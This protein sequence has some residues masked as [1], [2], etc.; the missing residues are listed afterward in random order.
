M[1]GASTTGGGSIR[2]RASH[3]FAGPTLVRATCPTNAA[4][5]GSIPK[6][7]ATMSGVRL[8][9][10][11]GPA[12]DILERAELAVDLQQA[13]LQEHRR[14]HPVPQV[15]CLGRQLRPPVHAQRRALPEHVRE[16][17]D[18][19]RAAVEDPVPEGHRLEG[20]IGAAIRAMLAVVE[21]RDRRLGH[22]LG[23]H[24]HVPARGIAHGRAGLAVHRVEQGGHRLARA[25]GVVVTLGKALHAACCGARCR[26]RWHPRRTPTRGEHR[27]AACQ[28]RQ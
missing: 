28:S 6:P 13:A 18:A 19:L 20:R 12:V 23:A 27:A 7:R 16:Q 3:G 22:D 8:A 25:R 9:H 1:V 11:L 26:S 15:T 4:L 17:R 5:A 21:E 24:G 14:G 10:V 2:P